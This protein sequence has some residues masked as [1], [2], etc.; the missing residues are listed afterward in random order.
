MK[1]VFCLEGF[2]YGDHRDRTS[3]VPILEM[4]NR[5]LQIPYIYHRC[6]TV[7]NLLFHLSDGKQNRFIKSILYLLWHFMEKKG[8]FLLVKIV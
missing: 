4:V 2:W 3:V 1:G 5:Y 7:K 8:R 6:A